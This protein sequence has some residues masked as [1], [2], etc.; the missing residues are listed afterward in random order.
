MRARGPGGRGASVQQIL[1]WATTSVAEASAEVV[2]MEDIEF[3]YKLP[4]LM[5]WT[6]DTTYAQLGCEHCLGKE[7]S[8][9]LMWGPASWSPVRELSITICGHYAALLVE[10]LMC[11]YVRT[12]AML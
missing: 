9:K 11:K 8:N 4:D 12:A 3:C 1:V 7:Q 6:Q 5:P 10:R 2:S